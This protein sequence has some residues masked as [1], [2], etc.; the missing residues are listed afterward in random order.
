MTRR[1]IRIRHVLP[2]RVQSGSIESTSGHTRIV[3]LIRRLRQSTPYRQLHNDIQVPPPYDEE[4]VA[5]PSYEQ[6]TGVAQTSSSSPEVTNV[7]PEIANSGN[8]NATYMPDRVVKDN[9]V[10]LLNPNAEPKVESDND[11]GTS[12]FRDSA[13]IHELPPPYS[14]V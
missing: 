1:R 8:E 13:L 3:W 14:R 6:A 7:E 4:N 11:N 10:E 5:P 9:D 12:D 2:R